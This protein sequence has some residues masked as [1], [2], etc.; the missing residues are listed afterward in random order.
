MMARLGLAEV[1]APSSATLPGRKRKADGL[2]RSSRATAGPRSPGVRQLAEFRQACRDARETWHS[3]LG[4]IFI[5]SIGTG[6]LAVV[7]GLSSPHGVVS[8]ADGYAKKTLIRKLI[9]A[10]PRSW[11]A[12]DWAAVSRKDLQAWSPDEA[13]VLKAFPETETAESI[14]T[15]LFGRP[16]WGLLVSCWACV[17]KPASPELRKN[18]VSHGSISPGNAEA[19]ARAA[20]ALHQET[21]AEETAAA[22]VRRWLED[23]ERQAE[24]GGP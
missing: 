8:A 21:G 22:A 18:G 10:C 2:D 13:G 6:V 19:I 11:H 17:W 24:L 15:L 3:L 16:D 4:E 23:M 9:F 1:E 12:A 5:A 14:S 7:E 20:A